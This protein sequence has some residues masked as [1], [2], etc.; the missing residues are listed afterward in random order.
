M[1]HFKIKI[2]PEKNSNPHKIRKGNR[3]RIPYSSLKETAKVLYVNKGIARLDVP[4]LDFH[5]WH[6][7]MLMR[8]KYIKKSVFFK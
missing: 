3:V 4:L 7:E 6:V 1:L 5:E 2:M 8:T